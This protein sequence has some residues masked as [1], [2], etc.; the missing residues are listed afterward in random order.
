MYVPHHV[1]VVVH[2]EDEHSLPFLTAKLIIDG[3][4]YYYAET[5]AKGSH[6]GEFNGQFPYVFEGVYDIQ[7]NEVIDKKNISFWMG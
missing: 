3:K 4:K 6:I 5:T 2:V 7:N 1:F